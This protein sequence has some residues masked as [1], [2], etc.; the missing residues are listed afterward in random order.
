[1]N[2]QAKSQELGL[3]REEMN[4]NHQAKVMDINAKREEQ[5]LNMAGK[6]QAA[7]VDAQI[8]Q[9]RVGQSQAEFWQKFRQNEQTAN[10]KIQQQK[11]QTLARPKPKPKAGG[12]NTYAQVYTNEGAAV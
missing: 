1:M 8:N 5:Q 11:A 9:Q 12:R 4:M 3:K 7:Q 2:L 10:Q 6:H